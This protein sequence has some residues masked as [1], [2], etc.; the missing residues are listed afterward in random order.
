MCGLRG[1]YLDLDAGVAHI[2]RAIDKDDDGKWIEKR[3]VSVE[4]R[5]R[6]HSHS[7]RSAPPTEPA[8]KCLERPHH[9]PGR[10]SLRR[11]AAVNMTSQG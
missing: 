10:P 5:G 1:Q 7:A 11:P 2:E 8:G 9:M 4:V 3:L 6:L